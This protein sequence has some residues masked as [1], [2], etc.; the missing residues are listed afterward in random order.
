MLALLNV[1]VFIPTEA[2]VDML[3]LNTSMVSTSSSMEDAC[4]QTT[5][6]RPAK[7]KNHVSDDANNTKQIDET[8]LQLPVDHMK[9]TDVSGCSV[10]ICNLQ[11][12]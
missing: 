7:Q 10:S 8:H 3:D 12:D 2:N 11:I 9:T 5:L 4:T 1:L 6:K